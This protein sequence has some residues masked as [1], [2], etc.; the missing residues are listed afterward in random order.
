MNR[1]ISLCFAAIACTNEPNSKTNDTDT[2]STETNNTDDTA[3][4]TDDLDA[5]G[6]WSGD[7][8]EGGNPYTL[9]G[10]H[11]VL[12]LIDDDG[13]L[14]GSLSTDRFYG[15][16]TS[17]S[18]TTTPYILYGTRE[19]DHLQLAVDYSTGG[20]IPGF[21]DLILSGDTLSGSLEMYPD[22]VLSCALT[23]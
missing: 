13:N 12:V 5:S 20:T 10:Y 1:W 22:L 3:T 9:Y 11:L 16:T 14:T 2:S 18:T 6:T 21:F 8:A 4:D 19:G 23:R 15:S 7:C 17:P